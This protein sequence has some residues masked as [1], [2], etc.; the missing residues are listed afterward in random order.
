MSRRL[1]LTVLV[2]AVLFA[3]AQVIRPQRANPPLDPSRTIH[4][5]MATAPA[6]LAVLDRSC[7]D[8][9]SNHAVSRW[10]A[11]V[12]PLSWLMSYAV[13]K[14]RNTVNFSEWAAYSPE[15][16]RQLLIASCRE[17]S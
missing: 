16:Q 11:Q 3:A 4:A 6:L 10:Y 12:A 9:H 1:M 15:R 7:N 13:E 8:C 17:A 5:Q 2:F 14:G